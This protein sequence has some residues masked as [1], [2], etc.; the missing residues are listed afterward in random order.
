MLTSAAAYLPQAQHLPSFQVCSHSINYHS[1]AAVEDP[2]LALTLGRNL[3]CWI[4]SFW[5]SIGVA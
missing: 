2:A 5:S 1:L 4:C 3:L